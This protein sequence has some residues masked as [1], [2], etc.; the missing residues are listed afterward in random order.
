[1]VVKKT[2]K[3]YL[4]KN[5]QGSMK[6][7]SQVVGIMPTARWFTFDTVL[8]RFKNACEEIWSLQMKVKKLKR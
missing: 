7:N 8:L 3:Y 5:F 4:L 6:K 2:E 1:M